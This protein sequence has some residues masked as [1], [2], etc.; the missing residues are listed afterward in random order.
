MCIYLIFFRPFSNVYTNLCMYARNGRQR[1]NDIHIL[2]VETSCWSSPH[3][4]GVVPHARAGMSLTALRDRL[5]LFG[6]SGTSSKCF[7]D[8]QVL[9]RN[10]MVSVLILYFYYS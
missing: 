4:G 3:V 6:G 9:D 8:L 10:E 7:D 5:Y 1:L 2:D